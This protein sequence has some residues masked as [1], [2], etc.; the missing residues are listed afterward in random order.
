[1]YC[2]AT[3]FRRDVTGERL[4]FNPPPVGNKFHSSSNSISSTSASRSLELSSTL[5]KLIL[6]LHIPIP[7]KGPTFQFS[8]ALFRQHC[9]SNFFHKGQS[10]F[11]GLRCVSVLA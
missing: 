11:P 4:S 3:F 8:G 9:L 7:P 2:D 1:M 10:G 6:F 5:S